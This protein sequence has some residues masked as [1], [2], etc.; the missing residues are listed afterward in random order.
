DE[1][2]SNAYHIPQGSLIY[3]NPDH[4]VDEGVDLPADCHRAE[5]RRRGGIPKGRGA[6]GAR[7]IPAIGTFS[8]GVGRVNGLNP[9]AA[10]RSRF[11]QPLADPTLTPF[12]TRLPPRQQTVLPLLQQPRRFELGPALL[13][14]VLPGV[15][16]DPRRILFLAERID[17]L[18]AVTRDNRN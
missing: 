3:Y 7:G 1:A 5:R 17:D 18:T 4:L 10:G 12:H 6:R 9:L 11:A 15:G 2:D 14:R 13:D 8:E 16:D